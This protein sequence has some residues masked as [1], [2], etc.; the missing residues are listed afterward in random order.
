MKYS[1]LTLSL[2]VSLLSVAQNR[3]NYSKFRDEVYHPVCG[4]RDSLTAA[5]VTAEMRAVDTT[6]IK[7]HIARYYSDLA[8]VESQWF[9]YCGD[10]NVLRSSI[11]NSLR[12]IHHGD[13]TELWSAAFNYA[14]F[15]ECE[16]TD[17]YLDLYLERVPEKYRT[18][19]DQVDLVR[20]NCR[21]PE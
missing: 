6:R 21:K 9:A 18:S 15:H 10:T 1:L 8:M 4:W 19:K 17:E 11:R 2:V 20:K 3:R 5:E 13:D 7:K 16:K 14:R 12:S